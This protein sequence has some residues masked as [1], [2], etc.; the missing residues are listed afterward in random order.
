[1]ADQAG[2]VLH[3][4]RIQTDIISQLSVYQ[5]ELSIGDEPSAHPRI[6]E[7]AG[8]DAMAEFLSRELSRDPDEVAQL[9]EKL[10]NGQRVRLEGLNLDD[11][12]LRR[13]RLGTP[14]QAA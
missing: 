3:I 10:R 1:V 2:G 13:L 6:R 11:A 5:L 4:L 8:D 9:M 14:R 12:T 7:I